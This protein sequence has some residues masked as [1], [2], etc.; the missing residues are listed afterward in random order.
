MLAADQSGQMA[1]LTRYTI[2]VIAFDNK[3]RSLLES[4]LDECAVNVV[5]CA[6][7]AEAEAFARRVPCSGILVDLAT[8]IKSKGP[9]KIIS[10]TL[11]GYYPTM[12]VKTMGD[13]ITPIPMGTV[14]NSDSIGGFISEICSTF[15]PRK[16]RALKRKEICQP[17]MIGV[18]R[19]YTLNLS[20][21]GAFIA[22]SYP[23][24]FN[25]A[26][27][28]TLSF[29]ALDI[30]VDV[31]VMKIYPWGQT[32]APGIGVA[33]KEISPD[34]ENHLSKLLKSDRNSDIDVVTV[35]Q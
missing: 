18:N 30:T 32:R 20:W 11:T 7:F 14:K 9:E 4:S 13:V 27:E 23:E 31:V 12:R 10:Y 29:P 24:I 26:D 1:E 5:P 2:L 21:G 34:F 8:M 22:D 28:C 16:L 15:G 25:E 19:G 33:Y 3:C 17:T 35:L 6:T